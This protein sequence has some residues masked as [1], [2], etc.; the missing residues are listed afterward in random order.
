MDLLSVISKDAG[1]AFVRDFAE[2]ATYTPAGGSARYVSVIFDRVSEVTDIGEMLQMDGV[3]AF[4]H[5]ATSDVPELAIGDMMMVREL[6]YRVVGV[7]PTGT[8]I[9]RAQLGI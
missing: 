5:C 3:A 7:E 6:G 1:N 2:R 4:M 9:T 8:N